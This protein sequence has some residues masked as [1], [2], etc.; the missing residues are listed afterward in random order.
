MRAKLRKV[1]F[2][3]SAYIMSIP[4][5]TGYYEGSRDN[6]YEGNEWT[7]TGFM[8]SSKDTRDIEDHIIQ[9]HYDNRHSWDV[10]MN[11]FFEGVYQ[12]EPW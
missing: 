12:E 3:S 4:N 2:E 6:R 9:Q 1:F 10:P 8:C 11:Y 5:A 7:K